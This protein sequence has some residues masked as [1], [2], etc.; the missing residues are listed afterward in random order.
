MDHGVAWWALW[1]GLVSEVYPSK[2]AVT[3]ASTGAALCVALTAC[4]GVPTPTASGDIDGTSMVIA[5]AADPPSLN[6][7]AGYAEHGAA[8]VYD[9]LLEHQADLGLRPALADELPVPAADGRSWTVELRTGVTFSDG[10]GF[11]AQDVLATYR[12]VLN[13]TFASPVRS[14]LSMLTDVTA[15]NTTT[16]QFT[17]DK[18]YAA[19]PQLLVLGILPSEALATPAPVTG[20]RETRPP[21]GTGPYRLVE[22]HRGE[23][24]VLEANKNYYG[25]A[26][27]V[28]KVTVRFVPDDA[29]RLQQTKDG[30]LDGA[31]L[32]CATAQS[33][34]G[35]DPFDVTVQRSAELL[36]VTLPAGQSVTGDPAM[37]LA[38]NRV[39]DRDALVAGPLAGKGVEASTPL[40]GSLAEFVEPNATFDLNTEEAVRGLDEAGWHPGPDGTRVKAGV[41]AAFTVRYP[42]GDSVAAASADAFAQ[43]AAAVG[44]RVRAEAG[45]GSATDA[46][47]VRFG[48]PFDPDLALYPVLRSGQRDNVGRYANP[49]V[50]TALDAGRTLTDPG[51]RATVYR[52][53]QRAY[54]TAPGMVVLAGEQTCAVLRRSWNGYQGV[55]T[56]AGVDE[57]WGPW[58]NLQKWAP[59]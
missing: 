27:A 34:S 53:A 24:M 8:K 18:P 45:K 51:Q 44:V 17:L 43:S 14:R 23:S 31:L 35:A 11:D 12:A 13:P 41:P 4:T 59:R 38:L 52:Q 28:T 22:W 49:A 57:T 33:F 40:P 29:A 7:L 9:G 25:G 5:V 19:F 15:V 48:T 55:V 26:P 2:R 56:A 32:P 42:V 58:W 3:V 6:P 39:V 1:S 30:K 21:V 37:R 36:A 50:D 20:G 54:V 16:V 46:S 10:T 47:V